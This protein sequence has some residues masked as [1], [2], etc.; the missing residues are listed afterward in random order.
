MD[1]IH[2]LTEDLESALEAHADN[3][4]AG[5]IAQDLIDRGWRSTGPDVSALVKLGQT[6][7]YAVTGA[8]TKVDVR[9]VDLEVGKTLN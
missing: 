2:K 4:D 9:Y 6:A 1:P 7:R 8:Q 3:I 5:Q